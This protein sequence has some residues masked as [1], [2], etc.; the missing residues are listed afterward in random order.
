MLI[1]WTGTLQVV[2]DKGQEVDWFGATWVRFGVAAFSVA[3]VL[4]LIHSFRSKSPLVNLRVFKDRNFA[5]GCLLMLVLGVSIY[6]TITVLPLFYQ[7]LLGYTAFTAGLVCGTPRYRIDHRYARH[8]FPGLKARR[9]LPPDFWIRGFRNYFVNFG[10]ANLSIGPT[11]FLWPII[12]T[13][14]ALSF[15]FVPI[16]TEAYG[17]LRNEQIGTPVESSISFATS[18]DRSGSR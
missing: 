18:A 4:F 11:T 3:F 1:V 12:I 9:A 14:F 17:T 2:L 10:T 7:E 8:C 6:A 15:V 13:G 16:T 5:V